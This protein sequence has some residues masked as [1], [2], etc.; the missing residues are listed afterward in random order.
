MA[1]TMADATDRAMMRLYAD[2]HPPKRSKAM[3]NRT[4]VI[5]AV[6]LLTLA[7]A[8][9]FQTRVAS[10]QQWTIQQLARSNRQL[11]EELGNAM[12]RLKAIEERRFS[13]QVVTASWYGDWEERAGNL[14]AN[15]DVFIREAFTVAHRTLPFGTVLMI[16]NPANGRMLPAVVNDRGPYISG[17]QLD[18]SEG[19]ARR[20]GF[21][22]K[23]VTEVRIYTLHL[24]G[25]KNESEQG[26]L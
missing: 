20:L 5:L 15:G 25:E 8:I 4:K 16:E 6:L 9:Y 13:F 22:K 10:Y 24:P 1:R 23:G 12:K 11:A 2:Y 21:H 19:L 3:K 17:R 14:T 7:G 26:N 18:V